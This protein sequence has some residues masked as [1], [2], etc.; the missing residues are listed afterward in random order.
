MIDPSQPLEHVI[1][2]LEGPAPWANAVLRI[3][4]ARGGMGAEVIGNR[5]GLIRLAVECLHLIRAADEGQYQSGGPRVRT[6]MSPGRHER[7]LDLCLEGGKPWAGIS[8]ACDDRIAAEPLRDRPPK[9]SW[10]WRLALWALAGI[11]LIGIFVVRR[12]LIDWL[13]G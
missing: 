9:P 7:L 4:S 5:A 13:A 6:A 10:P 11:T 8:L 3:E 1:T 2:H 12:W